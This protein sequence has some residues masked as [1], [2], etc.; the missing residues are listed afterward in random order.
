MSHYGRTFFHQAEAAVE[1]AASAAVARVVSGA[2]PGVWHPNGFAVFRLGNFQDLLHNQHQFLDADFDLE[3]ISTLGQ[4][5]LHVWPAGFRREM[6]NHPPLHSHSWWLY[7]RILAGTYTDTT[8]PIANIPPDYQMPLVE[9]DVRYQGLEAAEIIPTTQPVSFGQGRRRSRNSGE[10]HLMAPDLFHETEIPVADF[11]C[12]LLIM[13]HEKPGRDILAGTPGAKPFL[14]DRFDVS[15]WEM[16][17]MV[18]QL[19]RRINRR[20]GLAP[21]NPPISALQIV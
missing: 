9:Y 11:C 18:A 13:S 16:R 17:H 12:T 5:R 14:A 2:I 6:S 21:A 10:F 7:S 19:S 4:L 3:K 1:V 20:S 15:P 8:Y